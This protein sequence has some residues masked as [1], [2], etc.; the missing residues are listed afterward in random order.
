MVIPYGRLFS[1]VS[2]QRGYIAMIRYTIK[3]LLL[4]IPVV[5]GVTILIFTIMYFTPGDPAQL[6]MGPNA[7]P[8]QVAEKRTEMGLDR[9]YFTRLFDYISDVFIHG[10]LGN[11][12]MNNRSV[13]AE[14]MER[15]PR[16][17]LIAFMSVLL[18]LIVGIPIGIASAVGQNTWRDRVAMVVSLLGVSMPEFWLGLMLV[19]LFSLKLGWLPPS[20]IGSV[21]HYVLPCIA[22][23]FFG[24][25]GMA[26]Q[27][28]SSMLEVIRADY[29]T[30]ARVKGQSESKVIY[31][32][33]LRNALIPIITTVGGAFG[34][35]LGGALVIETVFSI[36][37]IGLYMCKAINSRDY[38]AIQ[39]SVIFLA[40][41]FSLVMLITDLV[42]ALVD[43]RIR[44]QY[45]GK[46]KARRSAKEGA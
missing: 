28:R 30:T 17:A 8:Q 1:T 40:I 23:S 13:S 4:M 32:H 44:S 3:R 37:G 2:A 46:K 12:Y 14:I 26:R 36:P 42:Y 9:P 29:I 31:S 27:T 21:S 22:C 19:I 11:S 16:T 45:Q 24:I 38:P 25:A 33:A 5:L 20:G 35:S 15:F 6:I 10:D 41:A 7:S 34:M 39:G 43:P 18:S